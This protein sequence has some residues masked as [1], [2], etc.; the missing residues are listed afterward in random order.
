MRATFIDTNIFMY[1]I[2]VDH[3]CKKPS[4]K[5]VQSVLSGELQA[6]INTE[7]L[8]EILYRYTAIGKSRIGYELFDTVVSTFSEIW[9]VTREDVL[10]A[11]KIQEKRRIKTRDAIHAATMQNHHV[12]QVISFDQDFDRIPGITRIIPE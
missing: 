9:S 11:R 1:A 6:A 2:G 3:P 8:Q 10:L 5:V 12:T 4:I 7:V